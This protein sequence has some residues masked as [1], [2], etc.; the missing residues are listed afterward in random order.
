MRIEAV[1]TGEAEKARMKADD[2]TVMF[3]NCGGQIVIIMWRAAL[4]G[5]GTQA[6]GKIG[7]LERYGAT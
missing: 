7:L 1:F 2:P 4:C 6:C 5:R 3:G